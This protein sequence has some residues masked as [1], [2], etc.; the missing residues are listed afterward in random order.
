MFQS[1]D[2]R[3]VVF[4]TEDGAVK[5]FS[6]SEG[7]VETLFQH[8]AM[9]TNVTMS[10]YTNVVVSGALGSVHPVR[11]HNLD[12][13]TSQE[14]EGEVEAASVRDVRIIQRGEAVLSCSLQGRLHV[15]DL[16]TGQLSL[17]IT[18]GCTGHA[19]CL[20]VAERDGETLA[21]VSGVAGGV[22]VVEL[23]T[24]QR[25]VEVGPASVPVRV[26]RFSPDGKLLVTG[27]DTG[28]VQVGDQLPGGALGPHCLLSRLGS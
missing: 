8:E 21:A 11:I 22:K 12:T 13:G 6:C 24:G 18:A 3:T 28:T 10:D 15:W 9:V 2:L 17:Q 16:T 23:R 25:L 19:T 5:V 7:T 27:H 4:G 26:V 20:D 14:C 1:R